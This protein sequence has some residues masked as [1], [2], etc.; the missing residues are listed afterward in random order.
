MCASFNKND[1]FRKMDSN[2]KMGLSM[3]AMKHR[4]EIIPKGTS[5]QFISIPGEDIPVTVINKTGIDHCFT[6]CP[7]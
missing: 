6:S 3:K 1:D 4:K 5:Y 7:S 2:V